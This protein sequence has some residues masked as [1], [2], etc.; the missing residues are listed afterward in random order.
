LIQIVDKKPK[1]TS[2]F[3]VVA[4]GALTPVAKAHA[5]E[6]INIIRDNSAA[7]SSGNGSSSGALRGDEMLTPGA[8]AGSGG[9]LLEVCSAGMQHAV[10][11][12]FNMYHCCSGFYCCC[13]CYCCLRCIIIFRF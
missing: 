13:F 8:M 9:Y 7:N 12:V 2:E 6:V 11:V 10:A 3:A 4:G 1:T 5:A